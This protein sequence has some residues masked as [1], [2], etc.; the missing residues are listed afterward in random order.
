MLDVT[1]PTLAYE[2]QATGPATLE[3]PVN[4]L[5]APVASNGDVVGPEG[6]A[7]FAYYVYRRPSAGSSLDVWDD[8]TKLWTPETTTG[9]DRTP[10]QLAYQAG[11][12]TP[13][14]GIIVG[15]G[16]RDATGQPQFERAVGGYPTYSVRAYFVTADHS[17][18]LLT[19]PSDNLTFVGT[20][21]RNLMVIGPG[22]GE[23]LDSATEARV[24]LKDQGLQT[25][26][27]LLM[28]RDTPGAT[29]TIDN[30]AGASIVL[31]PDGRIEITPAAGRRVVVAGDLEADHVIYL[32]AGGAVK[33]TLT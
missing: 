24:L 3:K 2:G 12:P 33:Q 27:R 9:V 29:V 21:E 8:A 6:L 15:A 5:V 30:A 22:D 28:Q 7:T 18:A 17:E 14:R 25:I 1:R 31:H 4:V 26:G 13:W 16:G 10:T 23:Q 32:P 11:D 20:A 19:G